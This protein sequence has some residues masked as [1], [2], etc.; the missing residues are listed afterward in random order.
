MDPLARVTLGRTDLHVTRLGFGGAPLSERMEPL[1]EGRAAATIEAAYSAGIRYFDTSP[2]YGNGKSELRLVRILR[3]LPRD[4]F[5]LSTKVGRVFFRPADVVAHLR[6]RWGSD[7]LFDYRFDYTRD[8][9]LRSYEQSLMRLGF[10]EVDALLIH[11]LDL[12]HHGEGGIG[13]R[14]KELEAGGGMAALCELKQR[15]E[16][17]AIGVGVNQEGMIPRFLE[18]FEVDFFLVAMPYTLLNQ[19]ALEPDLAL[20][21]AR[22]VGVVIGAPFASGVLVTG[23]GSEG[24]YGYRPAP[25]EVMDRVGRIDS[26][27]RRH[28]VPLPAAALQFPLG[29]PTVA[30]VIPGPASPVQV[31]QNLEWMRHQIAPELWAELK[32]EGLLRADAP[33]P[34]G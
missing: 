11:D 25:P 22:G 23:P 26:V 16:I 29:H 7:L 27:C 3:D 19:E 21:S 17:S 33:T 31:G 34:A 9:I 30:A 18:R 2:W 12:Y 24:R 28:G 10:P 1:D 5:V 14:F 15:G 4:S 32:A 8:G 20:C 6:K 13:E